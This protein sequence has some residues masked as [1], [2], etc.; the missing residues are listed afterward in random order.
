[1]NINTNTNFNNIKQTYLFSEIAARVRA[2]E[3]EHPDAKI[4]RM[5]IGDVTL[6]LPEKLLMP[7]LKHVRR[8]ALRRPSEDIR[9]STAT[10]S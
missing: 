7:W 9:R 4:I 2:Y 1:M 8:W 10:D 3:A 6:P 5:G